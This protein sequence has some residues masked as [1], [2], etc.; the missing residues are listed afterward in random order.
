MHGVEWLT[1]H[2]LEVVLRATTPSDL[3]FVVAA[4]ADPD[5]AQYIDAWTR[6]MHERAIVD[7]EQAHIM[8]ESDGPVGF[9]LLAGIGGP[10]RTIEL[11][12]MVITRKGLGFGRRALQL[13]LKHVFGVL[14][15]HRVWLDVK[16]HNQR[17]RRAYQTAGFVEEGVLRD[18]LA[19]GYG[20]ESLLVMSMLESEWVAE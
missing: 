12:R 5:T 16:V 4:E 9:V 10:N 20:Y 3:D 7:A 6:E 2:D 14:G 17:A 8:I 19:T 11:R 1:A 18:A 15:A 13:L